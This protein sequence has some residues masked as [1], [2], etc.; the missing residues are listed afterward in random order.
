MCVCVCVTQFGALILKIKTINVQKYL[1]EL[2]SWMET[3]FLTVRLDAHT[4]PLARPAP[5]HLSR[6]HCAHAQGVMPAEHDIG[7]TNMKG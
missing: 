5:S 1:Y 6:W 2:Q 3:P 4:G 7:D